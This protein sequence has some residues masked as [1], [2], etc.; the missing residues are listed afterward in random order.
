[1]TGKTLWW[2]VILFTLSLAFAV[3]MSEM[4]VR[5]VAPQRVV[6][7]YSLPDSELGSVSRPNANYFD[8]WGLPLYEYHVRTNQFG[9]RM[10][11]EVDFSSEI[12]RV[13]LLGDSFTFGW[14]V[15][16]EKSFVELIRSRVKNTVPKVQLLNAG[17]GAYSTAHVYKA[18]VRLSQRV[19]PCAAIYF[20][21]ANDPFD[22]VI[23]NIHYRVASYHKAADGSITIK[24][25]MV[26]S[27]L[28][29]FLF[30]W[31]PYT[32]LNHHS[33]LF[34][35]GKSI[36]KRL[37]E[38]DKSVVSAEQS[39]PNFGLPTISSERPAEQQQLIIQVTLAHIARLAAFAM[40]H[41]IPIMIAMIPAWGELF[42]K[43]A[44]HSEMN[45][46]LAELRSQLAKLSDITFVD[47]L[48]AM[49]AAVT[50]G[51]SSDDLYFKDGTPFGHYNEQ[52]NA[53]YAAVISNPVIEFVERVCAKQRKKST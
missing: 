46:I 14:G 21:N 16:I 51:F 10:D 41:D 6:R 3:C 34:I 8:R 15:E 7:E 24:D 53:V 20:M 49:R 17:V 2:N 48:D 47:R 38:K 9:F 44:D 30:S 23:T 4:A 36:L 33:H 29:R 18:L 31:T 45:V 12:G 27:P 11:E 43:E 42:D 52:G 13:L 37:A 5:V 50:N 39:S 32:W 35:L 1:M 19:R 26:Y 28:K 25:E 40:E 22:N